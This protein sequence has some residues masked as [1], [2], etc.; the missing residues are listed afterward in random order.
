MPTVSCE[1][2]WREFGGH[3]G[4]H[5]PLLNSGLGLTSLQSTSAGKGGED[6]LSSSGYT[7]AR[8]VVPHHGSFFMI[9]V[10]QL[11]LMSCTTHTPWFQCWFLVACSGDMR[12]ATTLV[13]GDERPLPSPMI[14]AGVAFQLQFESGVG[15]G[16][17]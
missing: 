15:V 17:S 9:S 4:F 5:G 11:Q 3:D 16:A 14:G 6:E 12:K 1:L 8:V 10:K 2:N 7:E 13:L